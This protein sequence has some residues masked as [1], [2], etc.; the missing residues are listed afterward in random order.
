[1][2]PL[3]GVEAGRAPS[4]VGIDLPALAAALGV[5]RHHDALRAD[6]AGGLGYELRRL[7]PDVTAVR[8]LA[9]EMESR[10]LGPFADAP[11]PA[12]LVPNVTESDIVGVEAPL[13]SETVRNI[14]AA[15]GRPN[16]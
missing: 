12:T 1:M 3:Y 15:F 11:D 16:V 5:D 6:D 8:E 14:S 9:G 2:G 10:R 4:A 13:W 7:Y